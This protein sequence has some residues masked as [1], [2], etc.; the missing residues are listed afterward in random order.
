MNHMPCTIKF[1]L[2]SGL[3]NEVLQIL[4]EKKIEVIQTA[5]GLC[6]KAPVSEVKTILAEKSAGLSIDELTPDE[7]ANPDIAAFIG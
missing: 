7:K 4:K 2:N 6:A 3:Q 1:G 5:S